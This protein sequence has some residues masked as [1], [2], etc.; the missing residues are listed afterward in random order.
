M[1]RDICMYT[2]SALSRVQATSEGKQ[3]TENKKYTLSI[4]IFHN[5]RTSKIKKK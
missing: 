4:K 2:T 3:K 5:I 1:H